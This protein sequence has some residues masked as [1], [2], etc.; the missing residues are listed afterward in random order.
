MVSF[1]IIPDGSKGSFFLMGV[2]YTTSGTFY[3]YSCYLTWGWIGKIGSGLGKSTIGSCL[4]K[5]II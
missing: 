5:Y 3:G 1:S 4:G 2:T